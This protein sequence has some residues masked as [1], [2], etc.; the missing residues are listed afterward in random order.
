M[1]KSI[2]QQIKMALHRFRYNV[3]FSF[4][5]T[6]IILLPDISFELFSPYFEV[7]FDPFFV[8]AL[9]L[10][11]FFLSLSGRLV[12]SL[13]TLGLFIIQYIQISHMAYFGRPLNPVDI[14]K[15]SGEFSDII[16]SGIGAW[17]DVWFVTPLLVLSFGALAYVFYK[18]R[19]QLGF[20]LFAVFVV[21]IALAVKPERAAR[22][23]LKAFLPTETRFS[24]HNSLNTFS[25][26][27]MNG[28]SLPDKAIVSEEMYAPLNIQKKE[29]PLPKLIVFVMG[30][31]LTFDHMSLFGYERQTTPKLEELSK[32]PGFVYKKAI[33]GAVS[34]HSS[35]PLFFNLMSEPGHLNLLYHGSANLFKL[36]KEA[37]YTTHWISAQDAKNTNFIGVPY[38]DDLRTYESDIY[39]FSTRREDHLLD[40]FSD[41][42]VSEGKHFV[43][44]HFRSVH[45]PYESNYEHRKKEFSKYPIESSE[46]YRR[47][48]NSYDN[49]VL[50]TDD[51]IYKIFQEFQK[52]GRDEKRVFLMTSD[53]GQLIDHRGVYGHNI[54][55]KETA[56]VPFVL[57]GTDLSQDTIAEINRYS[58]ISHYQIGEVLAGILGYE[59]VNPNLEEGEFYI[60]GNNLFTDYMLLRGMQKRS[61]EI[62]MMP[63]MTLSD[64]ILLR[65]SAASNK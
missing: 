19:R 24:I 50:Y 43:V 9:I 27:L 3:F 47:F 35:L 55:V 53:H 61:G 30:E 41:L 57:Y 65:K 62:D 22:K 4:F 8:L 11:G 44:L 38:I 63:M 1:I 16:S 51:I 17:R 13:V 54:L 46:R 64:Y 14:R 52:K 28:S 2:F 32:L 6:G 5:F 26:F 21:F 45:S 37:G 49:A 25:F 56:H 33:A 59:V 15:I 18:Y 48:L 10:F 12:F 40:L 36:A 60:H 31:S 42:D 20:S 23:S 39:H 58:Y 7:S 34:T 29:G